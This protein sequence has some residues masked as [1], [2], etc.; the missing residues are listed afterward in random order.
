MSPVPAASTVPSG[1]WVTAHTTLP[2]RSADARRAAQHAVRTG[3]HIDVEIRVDLKRRQ[4]YEI[5]FVH[6]RTFIR[7]IGIFARR[8]LQVLI[9]MFR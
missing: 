8:N 3:Q 2:R 4:Y 1:M 5:Q 9:R 7:R 6:I